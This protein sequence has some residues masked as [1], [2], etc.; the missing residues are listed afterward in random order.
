M[1]SLRDHAQQPRGT[2]TNSPSDDRSEHTHTRVLVSATRI[3]EARW[4][5]V[6][7][8]Y[9]NEKIPAQ[10]LPLLDGRG[11]IDIHG[12]FGQHS[13]RCRFYIDIVTNRRPT[14]THPTAGGAG[15]SLVFPFPLELLRPSMLNLL[16]GAV[17]IM[18]SNL[19]HIWSW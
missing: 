11:G 3:P 4:G 1:I 6:S 17:H 9:L 15:A 2:R 18:Q 12:V 19:N 13:R 8:A 7:G 10:P 16:L 14:P 5:E